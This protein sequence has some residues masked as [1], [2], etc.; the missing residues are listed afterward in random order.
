MVTEPIDVY[1][2]QFTLSIGPYGASLSFGISPAHPDPS[3]P[4]LPERVATIRMSVEHLKIMGLIIGRHVKK[5]E[6]ELDVTYEVPTKILN[7]LGIVQEDW[8]NFWSK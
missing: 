3:S 2:D 4:K 1:S 6:K 5:V 7:Q 8:D